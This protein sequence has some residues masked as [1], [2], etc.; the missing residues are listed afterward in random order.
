MSDQN[1][2]DAQNAIIGALQANPP[3]GFEK[4]MVTKFVVVAE[5]MDDEG[6]RW[7]AKLD[8]PDL[9]IWDLHGLLNYCLTNMAVADDE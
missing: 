8:S 6:D 7:I 4:S 5:M 1:T 2:L 9:T 3:E